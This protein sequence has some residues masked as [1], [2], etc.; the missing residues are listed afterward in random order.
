M[1]WSLRNSSSNFVCSADGK[2]TRGHT[3]LSRMT[4]WKTSVFKGILTTLKALLA[5]YRITM[6]Q[7]NYAQLSQVFW[8]FVPA[9]HPEEK[10][11]PK[12]DFLTRTD[13]AR[14][15]TTFIQT[16]P[17]RWPSSSSGSPKRSLSSTWRCFFSIT[18]QLA[19]HR[20]PRILQLTH[21]LYWNLWF[22][23]RHFN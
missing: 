7:S 16:K 19:K 23:E 22:S 4:V 5:G 15:A 18:K 21:F 3:R 14:P 10:Q 8:A 20:S 1:I 9:T 17:K 6:M 2:K 11:K 13:A 12:Q